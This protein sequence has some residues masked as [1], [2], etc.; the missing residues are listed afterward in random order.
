MSCRGIQKPASEVY[1]EVT[2]SER[3]FT[4][5]ALRTQRGKLEFGKINVY[6]ICLSKQ[7]IN[8]LFV[9]LSTANFNMKRH[10]IL[11]ATPVLRAEGV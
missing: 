9:I 5:E 2:W 1:L 10:Q 6:D 7:T 3:R 4:T 11:S 8:I